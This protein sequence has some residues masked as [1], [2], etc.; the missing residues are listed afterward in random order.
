MSSGQGLRVLLLTSEWPT[1]QHPRAVPF[2]VQQVQFLRAAGVQVEVF[3]FEAKRKVQNYLRAWWE[4]RVRYKLKSFDLI[5]AHFGQSG[6][7]AFPSPIPVVVT[8]HGSDLQGVVGA[9]GRYTWYGRLLQLVSRFVARQADANIVVGE[10]MVPHLGSA[11]HVHVIP[12]GVDFD[13]FRPFS[14]QV[15]REELG[16]PATKP[17]VLFP[18]SP[19]KRVKRFALAQQ[20]V[21]IL[22]AQQEVEL[23]ALEGVPH[24]HV[25]VYMAACDALLLTSQHEGSPTVI[26]EAL[27][28]NLPIVSV[29]VGDVKN[30]LAQIDGCY[31]TEDDAPETIAAALREVLARRQRLNARDN[32]AEQLDERRLVERIRHVY[33]QVVQKKK[34]QR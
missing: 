24:E 7:I 15:A 21:A 6:L 33:M 23:L 12:G 20:A 17:L 18:A 16:L 8:F 4:L 11:K 31:V 32:V 25:P 1:P 30:W 22:R 26:K 5:H 2:L 28:C 13:V 34:P 14:C 29:D 9:N 10:Q 3:S 19:A 27:A